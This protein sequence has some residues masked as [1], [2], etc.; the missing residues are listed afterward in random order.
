VK[1]ID[2]VEEPTA[3]SIF[4]IQEFSMQTAHSACP[5]CFLTLKTEI[6]FPQNTGELP[7]NY[8]SPLPENDTPHSHCCDKL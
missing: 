7:A 2:A 8:T 5:A 3:T 4:R 6:M 1:F